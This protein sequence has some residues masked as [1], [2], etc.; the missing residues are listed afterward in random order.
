[1]VVE[2]LAAAVALPLGDGAVERVEVLVHL[3]RQGR[4]LQLHLR[5][6][7]L[8]A[9]QGDRVPVL[10]LLFFLSASGPGREGIDRAAVY[11]RVDGLRLQAGHAA[12]VAEG[13]RD[14]V[15]IGAAL[16]ERTYPVGAAGLS[17][18]ELWGCA[19]SSPGAVL[20]SLHGLPWP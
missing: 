16:Q 7:L 6:A 9:E 2:D 18:A 3:L 15:R 5:L 1:M 10:L 13:Q 4:H 11:K 19:L 14:G 8:E 17:A 12:H 20:A